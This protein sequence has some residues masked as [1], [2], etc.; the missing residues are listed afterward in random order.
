MAASVEETLPVVWQGYWWKMAG[1]RTLGTAVFRS[2]ETNR[3]HSVKP[4]IE[5]I[6][7]L[8]LHFA[9][10]D[11]ACFAYLDLTLAGSRHILNAIFGERV[12]E[13]KGLHRRGGSHPP[14]PRKT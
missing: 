2:D 3:S 13:A 9:Y 5:W 14:L 6:V 10:L 12:S 7:L 1:A 11:F 8:T 4:L